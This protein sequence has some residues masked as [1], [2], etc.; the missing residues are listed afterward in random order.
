MLKANEDLPE[1]VL[2]AVCYLASRCNGIMRRDHRGFSK[3]DSSFGKSLARQRVFSPRQIMA[4]AWLVAKYPGQL[5]RGGLRAPTD[6]ELAA[7]I[8]AHCEALGNL[9]VR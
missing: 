4:A 8:E 3:E 9:A 7:Y 6:C 1:L 5:A 2:K